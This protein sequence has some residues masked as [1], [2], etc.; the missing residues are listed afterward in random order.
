LRDDLSGRGL[1]EQV[2][3]FRAERGPGAR[4]LFLAVGPD[5]RY[6][7]PIEDRMSLSRGPGAER[8]RTSSGGEKCTAPAGEGDGQKDGHEVPGR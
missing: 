3:V 7:D 5:G 2:R 4:L 8:R 1:R 6:G